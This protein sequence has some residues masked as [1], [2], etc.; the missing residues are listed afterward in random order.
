[1]LDLRVEEALVELLGEELLEG[2]GCLV[3]QL[4][5]ILVLLVLLEVI[6]HVEY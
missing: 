1:M 6:L 5:T 3:F 4:V 2:E